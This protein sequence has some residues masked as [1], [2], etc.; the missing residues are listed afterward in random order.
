MHTMCTL[1]E[2]VYMLDTSETNRPRNRKIVAVLILGASK[3]NR[4]RNCNL[5]ARRLCS[6]VAR[7]YLT[8]TTDGI[9]IFIG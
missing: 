6:A 1:F 4:L 8:R 3:T 5:A 7:M 9:V 2:H